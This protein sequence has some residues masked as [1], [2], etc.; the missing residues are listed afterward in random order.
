MIKVKKIKTLKQRIFQ[1]VVEVII[2]TVLVVCL[3][4][5]LTS[6]LAYTKQISLDNQLNISLSDKVSKDKIVKEMTKTPYDYVLYD[7]TGKVIKQT[8]VPEDLIHYQKVFKV[9]KN[10]TDN[11]V[12]YYLAQNPHYVLV[13]RQASIPEFTNHTLRS[14]SYNT[15]TYIIFIIGFLLVLIL[16]ITRLLKEFTSNFYAIQKSTQNLGTESRLDFLEHSRIAEFD[17]TLTVLAQKSDELAK[18]I[19]RERSEKKDLS[20]QIAAL[21]HDVKTPLTVI[22]GNIELLE[23]T[24]LNEQQASFLTSIN[25]SLLVFENYFNAMLNYSRQLSDNDHKEKLFLKPF[26]ADLSVEIE[27]ILKPNAIDFKMRDTCTT[28][29]FLANSLNLKRALINILVNAAQHAPKGKVRLSISEDDSH[30]IF[31]IWN[32]GQPFSDEAL[33]NA[34]KFF[35]TEHNSRSGKHYGIGLSFAKGV[36]EKHHG[37]LRISNPS[38][39]GAEVIL[40]I[41]K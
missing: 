1:T 11:G 38:S 20:F 32:D 9:K 21:A 33:K 35:F 15:L 3:I 39:G 37:S 22:K 23:M 16:A 36:A 40:S 19:E 8:N 26:L 28:D 25:N 13:V 12:T 10:L 5:T 4:L 14:I 34:A 31:S 6:V 2:G 18:L 7:K 30:L 17:D 27:D 29:S 41:K 24:S